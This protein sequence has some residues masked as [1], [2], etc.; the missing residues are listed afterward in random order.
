MAENTTPIELTL[1]PFGEGTAAAIANAPVIPKLDTEAQGA[2]QDYAK[3]AEDGLSE[4][5]KTAIAEFSA[6]IDVTNATAV[7]QY[8]AGTQ[9]KIANFSDSA[10]E[11]V[12]TKDIGEMGEKV[13]DLVGELKSFN[14]STE[15]KGF[16]ALFRRAK[17]KIVVMK[18]R[19][20]KA[21]VSVNNIVTVLENHQVT[22]MKDI[23]LLDKM[24]DT[25]LVYF[26]ELT[27]Y[28]LAGKKKL[29]EERATTL[30]A[31]QEKAKET[32]LPED[33]QKAADFADMCDRFEKK[34]HDLE[35]TRMVSIQMAP[36][37]RLVQ[38]NDTMMCEK[39]QST[40]LNTIPLWKSQM[41]I[42]LGL[43][44][45][46]EALKAQR[47]VTDMTNELL[48]KNAEKLRQGTV[49]VARE[50]ERGVVDIE[51]L[52]HTNA[53]LI[54]TL[55]EVQK[56]QTEGREKRRAAEVELSRLESELKQ[57]LLSVKS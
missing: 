12:R 40:I 7:M 3:Q 55:D 49:A 37:I 14:A 36:Q 22:L 8:G 42:A 46:E 41:V 45:S 9:Q 29:E 50:S 30:V 19:Y 33:A 56:I 20:D 25:N 52:K 47:A 17:K 48:K 11:N 10:L 32:G 27:M 26:K 31:L 57:K 16:F 15:D 53:E 6:K 34:I 23:A 35:L 18:A 28:I 5:E 24:Y 43:A 44:H 1:E 39:I 4:E 2:V 54:A 13:A 38:N 21:E 51:T